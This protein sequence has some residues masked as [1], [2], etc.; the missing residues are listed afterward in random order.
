LAKRASSIWPTS[1]ASFWP[2]TCALTFPSVP[3]VI[4]WAPSGMRMSGWTG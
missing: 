3:M 4:A 2:V 1:V